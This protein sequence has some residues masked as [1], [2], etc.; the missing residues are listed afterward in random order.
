MNL[1]IGSK[2]DLEF[3][4]EMLYEAFFWDSK[5]ERPNFNEFFQIPEIN[6]L[7]ANW[8]KIGDKLLIA[9]NDKENIGVAWY[10]LWTKENP[11]YGFVDAET[12]ELGIGIREEHRSQGIGRRLLNQLIEIAKKNGFKALSLSV[13][14]GNF[15]RYLYESEGFEKVGESG[16]SWTYK[17]ELIQ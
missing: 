7:L 3:A 15:A 6:K 8:G 4:K 12:P 10:R 2:N 9:E 1:R 13:D 17:L 5:M 16:T 11:S 14:P